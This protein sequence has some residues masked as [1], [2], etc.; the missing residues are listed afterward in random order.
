MQ[1]PGLAGWKENSTS[2]ESPEG[3]FGATMSLI[4]ARGILKQGFAKASDKGLGGLHEHAWMCVLM[5][6]RRRGR[7]LA[8]LLIASLSR[9]FLD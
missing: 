3:M 2:A 6:L 1:P 4:C 7:L 8:I 5:C 9:L